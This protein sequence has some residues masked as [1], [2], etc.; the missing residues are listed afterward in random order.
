MAAPLP[1][2]PELEALGACC[3]AD[4]PTLR[5]TLARLG[6]A[7]DPARLE[8]LAAAHSVAGIVAARMPKA[9]PGLLPPAAAERL[10]ARVHAD[11]ALGMAQARLTMAAVRTLE[12][13]EIASLVMKGA[14][15]ARQLYG[16]HPEWRPSNDIDLLVSPRDFAAAGRALEA[17]G[18]VRTWPTRLPS[19][20]AAPMFDF[21]ANVFNYEWPA[22][23]QVLELHHR[24]SP[25][26]FWMTQDFAAIAADGEDVDLGCGTVR[27]PGGPILIAYL[28]WHAFSLYVFR[29]KWFNDLA[30]ALRAVGATSCA[31]ACAGGAFEA[32]PLRLADAVLGALFPGAGLGISP[33]PKEYD[34]SVR[35]VLRALETPTDPFERRTLARLPVE[36]ADVMRRR[37]ISSRRAR[38]WDLLYTLSDP[39]DAETLRL[40]PRWSLVYCLGGPFLAIGRWLTR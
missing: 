21:L 12:A 40:S 29:L 8:S 35:Q 9:A 28:A 14:A 38:A 36:F 37:G 31:Q 25:N 11:T 15:L 26:P 23:G 24:L 39:R 1:V 18:W 34:R 10:S 19:P 2:S 13:A 27:A 17:A 22:N 16:D 4:D 32:G 7:L 3:I 33:A 30:L 20:R 5:S 6:P